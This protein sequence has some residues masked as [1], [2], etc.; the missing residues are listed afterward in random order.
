MGKNSVAKLT[1]SE[2]SQ[3][4]ALLH[5]RGSNYSQS[6][7]HEK[8]ELICRKN[9]L[10]FLP[11]FSSPSSSPM[12]TA[13]KWKYEVNRQS[14]SLMPIRNTG[15]RKEGNGEE[16][17]VWFHLKKKEKKGSVYLATALH[18]T[19]TCLTKYNQTNPA[20]TY[21]INAPTLDSP[22]GMYG[23]TQIKVR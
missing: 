15:Q 8:A 6:N 5:I 10:G 11:K 16:Q 13:K 9:I 18:T 3:L 4:P 7:Y 20:R 22:P 14:K 1:C 21:F 12:V 2:K 23:P 17:N 19:I